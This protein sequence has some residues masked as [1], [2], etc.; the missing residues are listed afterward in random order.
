[1]PSLTC[2]CVTVPAPP[3]P[4]PVLPVVLPH[5]PHHDQPCQPQMVI[6]EVGRGKPVLPHTTPPDSAVVLEFCIGLPRV[7]FSSRAVRHVKLT[8]REGAAR[9]RSQG[10]E[11]QVSSVEVRRALG[12][13]VCCSMGKGHDVM[14]SRWH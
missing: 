5:R 12:G 4:L 2:R 8:G 3:P 7:P 6:S 14:A 13:Q 1:M 11:E 9:G 10:T